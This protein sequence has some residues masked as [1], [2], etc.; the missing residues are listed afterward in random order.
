MNSSASFTAG[1]SVFFIGT[2][3]GAYMGYRQN[4]VSFLMMCRLLPLPFHPPSLHPYPTSS[5]N[6]VSCWL[7]KTS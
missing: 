6:T 1:W 3:G 5:R 4:M 7:L 2:M